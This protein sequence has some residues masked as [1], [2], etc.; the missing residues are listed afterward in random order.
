MNGK[1]PESDNTAP[2]NR[3]W[4]EGVNGLPG[5]GAGDDSPHFLT[6]R[7][8]LGIL[9]LLCL[10]LAATVWWQILRGF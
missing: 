6:F 4:R 9:V 7:R 10:L 3:E 1:E 2:S 5:A 8:V